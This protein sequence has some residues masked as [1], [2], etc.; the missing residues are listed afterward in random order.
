M[1]VDGAGRAPA[2]VLARLYTA[3]ACAHAVAGDRMSCTRA[4]R[5]AETAV[6]RSA[7]GQAPAWAGYFTPAHW[8]GTALRCFRDLGMYRQALRHTDGA[9]DL[10]G[11]SNRTQALH[12]ALIAATHADAGNYDTAGELGV[13]ALDFS[14]HVQSRRV[15]DR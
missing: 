5:R 4:L 10:T 6:A 8:A 12:T 14:A 2:A 15:R 11:N 1:A 3:Q 9:L 7:P 13:Q